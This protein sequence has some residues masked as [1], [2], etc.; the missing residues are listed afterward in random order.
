[1]VLH[2]IPSAKSRARNGINVRELWFYENLFRRIAID[3]IP[4]FYGSCVEAR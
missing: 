2:K 3:F 1:M 4:E